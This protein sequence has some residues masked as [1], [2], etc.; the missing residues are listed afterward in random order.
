[1]NIIPPLEY[2]P[3]HPDNYVMYQGFKI[4]FDPPSEPLTAEQYSAACGYIAEE[5]RKLRELRGDV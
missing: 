1:M 5:L 3:N 4:V 2:D